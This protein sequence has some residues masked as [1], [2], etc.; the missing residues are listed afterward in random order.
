MNLP[1]VMLILHLKFPQFRK[2]SCINVTVK[3]MSLVIGCMPRSSVDL[4]DIVEG[5]DNGWNLLDE[6][7]KGEIM[8][9]LNK[10]FEGFKG[11][12]KGYNYAMSVVREKFPHTWQFE[13]EIMVLVA[14]FISGRVRC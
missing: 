2:F 5:A 9:Y 8:E 6:K 10:E 14:K 7:L 11:C 12:G 3:L 13:K 4:G 1:A